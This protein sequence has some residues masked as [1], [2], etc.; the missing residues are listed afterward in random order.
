M[1][2]ISYRILPVFTVLTA[3][4]WFAGCSKG[5]DAGDPDART[6]VVLTAGVQSAEAPVRTDA[7]IPATATAR[8]WVYK[9]AL[10]EVPAP[11][12]TVSPVVGGKQYTVPVA[13]KLSPSDGK[14]IYLEKG[15]YDIYSLGVFSGSALTA[16]EATVSAGK[17]GPLSSGRDYIYGTVAAV[18]APAAPVTKDVNLVYVHAGTKVVLALSKDDASVEQLSVTSVKMTPALPSASTVLDFATGKIAPVS[19]VAAESASAT[20]AQ[21]T[22]GSRYSYVM[23]PLVP[24]CKVVFMVT[25]RVTVTG[26]GAKDMT[27]KSSYTLA[28]AFEGGKAYT[29]G[30]KVSATQIVFASGLQMEDWDYSPGDIDVEPIP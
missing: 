3:A 18:N 26:Q 11:V 24:G 15:D 2:K 8:V 5:E 16:V 10:A 22:A 9:R 25:A 13:G 12:A 28:N 21:E 27:L 17:S 14:G 30:A 7:A 23:L 6:T 1:N 4:F 20:M 29:L 19:A